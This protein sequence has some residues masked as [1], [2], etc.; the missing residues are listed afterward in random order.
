MKILILGSKGMAGHMISGYLSKQGHTIHTLARENATFCVDIEDTDKITTLFETIKDDYEFIINCIGLLVKQSIDRPDR[1]A[2]INAWFP[3]MVENKIKKSKTKLIHLST[4]CVFD[5]SEGHYDENHIHTEVNAYG[6]SKSYGEINNSKDITFRMSI[7]GPE[8]KNHGTGLMNWILKSKE[9][10]LTGWE[11]AL[12]NG[13]TT[14]QLAKCVEQYINNATITGV[15]HLVNN[16]VY[17]SKYELLNKIN[18][19]YSL[20]KTILKSQG[21]KSVNKIL[22]N[23]RKDFEFDIPNYDIQLK[24]LYE[25]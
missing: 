24:E 8:I 15:F 18:S 13:I 9:S 4:D 23:T 17:I 11:N 25:Y 14:L 20:G 1:A 6:K 7:I 2:I 21:P 22:V 12:W 16:S 3:H 10:T 19:Q 5:G